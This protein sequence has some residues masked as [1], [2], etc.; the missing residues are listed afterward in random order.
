LEPDA[1][2]GRAYLEAVDR[3][4]R[5]EPTNEHRRKPPRREP[6]PLIVF[7]APRSGTTYLQRVMDLHPAI[8]LSHET[9]VF[10]W[11]HAAI[12][13]LPAS[14]QF[15][16]TERERF[17]AHLRSAL[18][19]VLRD[20]Y[21]ELEP[22]TRYWGDKNPHYADP[23]NRGCLALTAELFPGTRF[24]NIVRD[25]RDVVASLLRRNHE[26]GDPWVD[27]EAAHRTWLQHV[28]IGRS[29]GARQGPE[30]YLEIR[31][32]DF[33]RDDVVGAKELCAFLDLELP[34]A[35]EQFCAAQRRQRTPLSSP[36]RASIGD[37]SSSDWSTVFSPE[38]RLRS[39]DL[40]GPQ[41]VNLGYETEESIRKL[42]D[43]IALEPRARTAIPAAPA[44]PQRLNWGCGESGEPGWINSDIKEGP[45][46]DISRDIRDGLPIESDSL[47]YV[48]S[49]HALPMIGY[50]DLVPVLRELHRVLKPGGVLRLALPDVDKG[51]RAY[52]AGDRSYFE[53][54]DEDADTLSGKFI[55]HMLWFGYSVSM[56]TSEFTHELLRRAGFAEVRDCGYR[57]TGSEHEGITELDN[58]ERETFFVEAVKSR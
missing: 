15:V 33:V 5:V 54:P 6:A 36:T 8:F 57:E 55:L 9:R 2:H 53:V 26:N 47:D 45:G 28:D 25:G 1:R 41:L 42:R 19:G 11:L 38:E 12:N 43:D 14:D 50:P 35:V 58:R 10:A 17:V 52:L 39:L 30:S 13:V 49:I 16:V 21:E 51:I 4:T 31:Y 32:E 24:V 37:L 56:F 29:F 27:F 20:F 46:V 34:P 48:V 3:V 44:Y 7:G 22:S 23:N 18:P 40:L